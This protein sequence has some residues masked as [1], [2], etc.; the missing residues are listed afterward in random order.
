MNPEIQVHW[1]QVTPSP[2]QANRIYLQASDAFLN[3]TGEDPMAF[4]QDFSQYF[5]T[6]TGYE[7]PLH[8]PDNSDIALQRL[9]V[10]L[11]YEREHG[12]ALAA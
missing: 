10:F 7:L 6:R 4:S 9:E 3:V 1:R 5:K 12:M 11:A 2:A 8:V